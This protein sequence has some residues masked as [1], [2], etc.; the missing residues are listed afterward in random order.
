[1]IRSLGPRTILQVV[2]LGMLL[3]AL[4][5][6]AGLVTALL[7]VERL[8]TQSHTTLFASVHAMEASR[9]LVGQVTDM[10]RSAQ[11]F[12]ILGDDQLY[13]LYLS[14]RARARSTTEQLALP[15][16][17]AE[18]ERLLGGLIRLQDEVDETV[19]GW[20]AAGTAEPAEAMFG[21]LLDA[22][23]RLSVENGRR[24]VE[25][26]SALQRSAARAERVL[27]WQAAALIPATLVFAAILT[28]LI[29]RPLQQIDRA[30]HRL[31][32]G[33]FDD[34]I[35][36]RGPADLRLLGARLDALRTRL[37]ELESQKVNF[38]R[39]VSHE[40]KTPLTAIREGAELFG[41]RALG[42]LNEG[43]AEVAGILRQNSI[44]LQK[45]IENLLQFSA[46]PP[47]P[48]KRERVAL[49]GLVEQVLDDQKLALAAKGLAVEKALEP[50]AVTGDA[51]Q[52]RIVLDN[53]LSNAIKHSPEGQAL[54]IGLRRAGGRAVL[55]VQD[56]GPGIPPHERERVF[57]SFYQGSAI[58]EGHVK[59][60]GLGLAIVKE[61]VI[62]HEGE[63]EIVADQAPG[64]HFR[65]HLPL[66]TGEA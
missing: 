26:A 23:R 45:L 59:G 3:V 9:L 38:L 60:T 7:Q 16:L 37:V 10:A 1:M 31:G 28:V 8:A 14:H 40:L 52:L 47:L 5:L 63:V 18:Q 55:D 17:D 13:E 46:R 64:A 12:M 48:R 19:E 2:L 58:A 42:E 29:A 51:E 56:G 21:S 24:V 33:E 57:E 15:D 44:R 61:F 49:D 11:Q 41:D 53:L 25:E 30:I 66:D 32:R 6:I 50:V 27:L 43:Q 35:E 20:R 4:P 34:P 22:A 62:L 65:V 39:Q 36:I 54:G